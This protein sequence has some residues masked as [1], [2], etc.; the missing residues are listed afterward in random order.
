MMKDLFS[1]H[2]KLYAS[3]RPSYPEALY[4]FLLMHVKERGT[5][6]DCA[7][8]NGQAAG[9]LA[10]YFRKVHATDI[11]EKQ[12]KEAV[13]A[14]NIYYEVSAAE[15]TTF[16]DHDFDLITVA[17]ALHWFD[18]ANFYQE[19]KRVGKPGALLAVWGYNLLSIEAEIDPLI[20]HF[21]RDVVGPYWDPAR[22]LVDE[23]YR[24]I[25]FPFREIEPPALAIELDWNLAQ[26]QGYLESWSATQNYIKANSRNPVSDV[27]HDLQRYWSNH[28]QKHVTFP[29]FMRAGVI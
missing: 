22:K 7:T 16:P 26:L 15:K 11:S 29:I 21:Y 24:T 19:V 25:D 18:V 5:A 23:A 12:L 13:R 27:I 9:I 4:D 14:D 1:S 17:Q 28:E 8:G 10:K 2:A 3:F 20:R 6:W